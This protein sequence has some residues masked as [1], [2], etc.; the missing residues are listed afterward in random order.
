MKELRITTEPRDAGG[1]PVQVIHVAGY[2]DAHSFPKFEEEMLS[3]VSHGNYRLL[4]DLE[5]VSYICS[6]ALG[7]LMSIFRQVRHNAGDIVIAAMPDKI[8]NIFHLLGFSRLIRAFST[9]EEAL[10]S[11]SAIEAR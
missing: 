10:Q 3:L 8:A 4:L 5:N 6:T 9:E 7:L 2:I 11:L 1:Y